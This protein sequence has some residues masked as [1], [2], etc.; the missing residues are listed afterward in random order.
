MGLRMALHAKN[1]NRNTANVL[2][3]RVLDDR[4]HI[5]VVWCNG[6]PRQWAKVVRT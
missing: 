3:S 4:I 2:L 6:R 5:S 1:D